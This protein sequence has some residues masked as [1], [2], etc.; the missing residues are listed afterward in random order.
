MAATLA[1]KRA[2]A[3]AYHLN[4]Y[5]APRYRLF[6]AA[7]AGVAARGGIGVLAH[8]ASWRHGGIARSFGAS[9]LD[10]T[11]AL[12]HSAALCRVQ[13]YAYRKLSAFYRL[14]AALRLR[15]RGIPACSHAAANVFL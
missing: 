9:R 15:R 3:S 13:A 12:L 8:F 11:A 7:D 6:A 2:A 4:A 5:S 1:N 10:P 14:L